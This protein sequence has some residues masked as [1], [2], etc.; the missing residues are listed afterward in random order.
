MTKQQSAVDLVAQWWNMLEPV[1][2]NNN[3]PAKGTLAGALVVLE[4][5]KTR[6]ALDIDQHRAKR[7]QSQIQG[8]GK[9]S[10]Q[11]RAYWDAKADNN[12]RRDARLR[13]ALHRQGW[14]VTRIREHELKDESRLTSRPAQMMASAH[15]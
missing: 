15:P 5:L 10:V 3:L 1:R 8:V 13:R 2:Q 14:H 9:A 6:Y 4:R 11:R 12:R 7:G